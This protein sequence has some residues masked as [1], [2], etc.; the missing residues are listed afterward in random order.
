[1]STYNIDLSF[2]LT[3]TATN[4]DTDKKF[5]ISGRDRS[6]YSL[7]NDNSFNGYI[8]YLHYYVGDKINITYNP[9]GITDTS[10]IFFNENDSNEPKFIFNDNNLVQTISF[11]KYDHYTFGD[12]SLNKYGLLNS[13]I[14]N[15]NEKSE[16]LEFINS[17]YKAADIRNRIQQFN[18]SSKRFVGFYDHIKTPNLITD[19]SGV[20]NDLILES[21]VSNIQIVT[22]E[23][24]QT[25]IWSNLVVHGNVQIVK[26]YLFEKNIDGINYDLSDLYVN[27]TRI[28]IYINEEVA[29]STN[30]IILKSRVDV[31]DISVNILHNRANILDISTNILH[32]RTNLL[33]IST[34]ILHDRTNIL[35]IS[36]NILHDRTNILDISTN[37]LHD[38]T[39]ILDISTNILHDRT[40]I[41]DIST[42]IL[43]DITNILDISTNILHDRTNIL[44][45]STNILHD[46][47]NILHNRTNILDNS[48]NILHNRTNILD[49]STN[50][51]HNRANI[52]DIS[53]NI[54]H[55]R[56]N[57]LDIST[58]ILHNRANILDISTNILD[59]STNILHNSLNFLIDRVNVIDA[60]YVTNSSF[61][62]IEISLNNI[63]PD[64]T[65]NSGKFLYT[66]GIDLLWY[67]LFNND[68]SFANVD[69]SGILKI[70]NK[71][72]ALLQDV[73]N[74]INNL[75]NGAPQAL[76]TLKELA[77]AL[78]NSNNFA[79]VIT[80]KLSTMDNLLNLLNNKTVNL[81]GYRDVSFNNVD[82]SGI[83][84]INNYSFPNDSS[85]NK[86]KVLKLDEYEKEL[87]WVPILDEIPS[88]SGCTL[89]LGGNLI[90]DDIKLNNEFIKIDSIYTLNNG[91]N[92]LSELL[93]LTLQSKW[94][95]SI[96]DNGWQYKSGAQL[97][98]HLTTNPFNVSGTNNTSMG[99]DSE[100]LVKFDTAG[101]YRISYFANYN[102]AG[103]FSFLKFEIYIVSGNYNLSNWN[104]NTLPNEFTHLI[105]YNNSWNSTNMT[106][107]NA[108]VDTVSYFNVNDRILLTHNRL[109][110]PTSLAAGAN[111]LRLVVQKIS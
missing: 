46:R 97:G 63:I 29:R 70:N 86:G 25:T 111:G 10:F 38:R 60:S 20:S 77:D 58:N 66:N 68:V 11:E 102:M 62:N 56:A 89:Q 15:I 79:Q 24:K 64:K 37:I 80:T 16:L 22:N 44:D 4:L 50:I 51:L 27:E 81:T 26:G 52:L 106:Y 96:I 72:V 103:N 30:F 34:N 98:R 100:N 92:N 104:S 91:Q 39:N 28:D 21:T 78:D 65:N 8:R 54:L 49:N 87:L 110:I 83:L 14:F 13:I 108:N 5:I 109:L 105:S 95:I 57:I 76:D 59:I 17:K 19:T 1:M 36:T 55:N 85:G 74:A 31:L 32:D 82:I 45:I 47:T 33:D 107:M 61:N 69:I 67:T 3:I 101:Y 90:F 48:V 2:N 18:S 75:I 43:H 88:I 7:L 41:L 40:N 71:E 84:K 94:N 23:K 73:S 6:N 93:I 35:D 9:N 53:T 99:L 42:N 12:S